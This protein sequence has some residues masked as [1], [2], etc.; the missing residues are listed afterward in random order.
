MREGGCITIQEDTIINNNFTLC[1]FKH[2]IVIGRNC[3]IGV[4]FS[5][6]NAD[7]HGIKVKDRNKI[8]KINS[9]DI[10]IGDNCF[11]GNN[12][13]ILKGVKL[14]NNCVVGNASVVT[15]SFADNSLIAGNPAR[16]IKIIEQDDEL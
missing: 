10:S 11:I 13:T 15:R 12:V 2:K 1:A 3:L 6:I 5:A 9:K 14:G 16:L 7:Y 4:N 8:E